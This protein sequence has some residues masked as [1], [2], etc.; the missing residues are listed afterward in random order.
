MI[1]SRVRRK[2]SR[3]GIGVFQ[4]AQTVEYDAWA[5]EKRQKDIQVCIIVTRQRRYLSCG[6][7]KEQVSRL[8]R[9]S[10]AKAELAPSSIAP[11]EAPAPS[12]SRPLKDEAH[13]R[14]TVLQ[15]EDSEDAQKRRLPTSPYAIVQQ[16]Y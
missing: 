1:E 12:I 6:N 15:Q 8:A 7:L 4:F 2:K 5:D 11:T 10:A 3:G 13:P 9:E 16:A 14:Y